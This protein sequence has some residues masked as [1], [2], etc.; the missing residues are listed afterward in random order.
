MLKAKTLSLSLLI[1][2]SLLSC[3]EGKLE[4]LSSPHTTTARRPSFQQQSS[5]PALSLALLASSSENSHGLF[6]GDAQDPSL[7]FLVEQLEKDAV[8][9]SL[10]ANQEA[11]LDQVQAL[12]LL[13]LR[14]LEEGTYSRTLPYVWHGLQ[15]IAKLERENKYP[16]SRLLRLKKWF[17]SLKALAYY[18]LNDSDASLSALQEYWDTPGQVELQL[19]IRPQSL[20]DL[21]EEPDKLLQSQVDL[22][23]TNPEPWLY[24]LESY[25]FLLYEYSQHA[26]WALENSIRLEESKASQQRNRKVLGARY[27]LLAHLQEKNK[28][29]NKAFESY[30]M[31]IQLQSRHSFQALEA[32]RKL[33]QDLG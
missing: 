18:F 26:S 17:F 31:V 14:Q 11:N 29:Y 23:L 19:S 25:L 28:Q 27:F 16:A 5:P 1:G 12:L 33:R 13:S 15:K 21:A 22:R 7:K 2:G 3:R 32:Q 30:Q 4:E 24:D 20:A 6:L 9:E 10:I 8:Q